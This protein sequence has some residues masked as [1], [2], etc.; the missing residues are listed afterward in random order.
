MTSSMA[1]RLFLHPAISELFVA[2]GLV[3]FLSCHPS[4]PGGLDGSQLGA[5]SQRHLTR[6]LD[7]VL[8]LFLLLL[9]L[10]LPRLLL[11][12]RHLACL[13]A[14]QPLALPTLLFDHHGGVFLFSLS[15][16]ASGQRPTYIHAASNCAYG[17]IVAW[18]PHSLRN[19]M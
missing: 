18:R 14:V 13:D 16:L 2:L 10:L 5:W 19:P 8:L 4:Q 17:A 12:V 7:F 11:L 15:L 1:T 3:L 6:R 9:P